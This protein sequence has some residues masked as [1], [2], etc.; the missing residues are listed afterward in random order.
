MVTLGQ[1]LKSFREDTKISQ[2]ALETELGLGYGSVS[3]MESG[4]STP[5][6]DMVIKI[7]N[8]LNLNERQIDYLIGSRTELATL[9]EIAKVVVETN[10]IWAMEDAFVVLHDDHFRLCAS[11]VGL[12][13]IFGVTK[14]QWDQFINLRNVV[15]LVL[16]SNSPLYDSFL[17]ENNPKAEQALESILLE[18]YFLMERA[19]SEPDYI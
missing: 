3:R 10:E 13:N 12:R 14:E 8:F 7:A 15:S 4:L 5:K 1:K 11:T 2:F 18:Y 6:R 9:N 16:D 17:P 19:S